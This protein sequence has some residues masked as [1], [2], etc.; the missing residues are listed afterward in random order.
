MSPGKRCAGQGLVEYALLLALVAIVAAAALLLLG[1]SLYTT[2]YGLTEALQFGCGQVSQETF[3]S[4]AG[5][6]GP[7]PGS[8]ISP[9]VQPAQGTIS[10]QYWFCHKGQDIAG[11]EGS[12]VIAV[13][14]GVVRFAGWSD[15][16]Y[17]YMVVV[18]HGSYQTLYAHLRTDPV[19][20]S[21]QTVSAGQLLGELGNTGFSTGPHLHFEIRL[22]TELV[23]PGVYLP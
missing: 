17:G 5:E 21:G 2:F 4:Y 1:R 12:P 13:A 20:N 6:G 3:R 7:A 14:D 15:K 23:D 18:D 11:E 8:P 10:Q 19:V 22:G 9:D 16:G